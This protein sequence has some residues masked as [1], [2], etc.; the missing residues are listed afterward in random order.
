MKKLTNGDFA[1]DSDWIK[2][3]G[4]TISGGKAKCIQV[5]YIFY[6]SWNLLT[7]VKYYK[8]TFDITNLVVRLSFFGEQIITQNYFSVMVHTHFI[9]WLI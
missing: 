9:T 2:G 8:V 4:W 5:K 3:T 6:Q 1:T 7:Q